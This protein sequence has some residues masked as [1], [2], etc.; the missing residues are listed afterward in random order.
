MEM[1]G[2]ETPH[3]S[4]T[5]LSETQEPHVSN[6]STSTSVM[7]CASYFSEKARSEER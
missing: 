6:L 5:H 1:K 4:P 7:Q 2:V 3:L